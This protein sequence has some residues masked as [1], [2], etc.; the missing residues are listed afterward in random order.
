MKISEEVIAFMFFLIFLAK[1]EAL[2]QLARQR[3]GSSPQPVPNGKGA[4]LVS[5]LEVLAQA[6]EGHLPTSGRNPSFVLDDP[7]GRNRGYTDLD[8]SKATNENVGNEPLPKTK[9]LIHE[10]A[11]KVLN[12]DTPKQLHS[13]LLKKPEHNSHNHSS[14]LN[15]SLIGKSHRSRA[16]IRSR[17]QSFHALNASDGNLIL[18]KKKGSSKVL[19]SD[20]TDYGEDI[21]LAGELEESFQ[22]HL[23]YRLLEKERQKNVL[24]TACQREE[25]YRNKLKENWMKKE[26]KWR[27]S[28]KKLEQLNK[29]KVI[30]RSKVLKLLEKRKRRS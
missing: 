27:E 12:D 19:D 29:K 24:M 3:Y 26:E 21:S 30:F 23:A 4:I 20:G 18:E 25:E 14:H 13:L 22:R 17:N 15:D 16:P 28:L 1:I 7:M 10:I 11:K 6:T 9:N 2:K 8:D 5:N